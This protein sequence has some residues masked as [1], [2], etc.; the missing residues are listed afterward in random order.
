MT[1]LRILVGSFIGFPTTRYDA[2][3]SD[4]PV[5]E[6]LSSLLIEMDALVRR[7]YAEG[8]QQG[9]SDTRERMNRVAL[10]G[11]EQRM[12]AL[13]GPGISQPSEQTY[14]PPYNGRRT[15]PKVG[16]G[17]ASRMNYG[18][19]I[20]TIRRGVLASPGVGMSI[21]EMVAFCRE[22]GIDAT[23]NAVRDSVKRLRGAEE[24][25]RIDKSYF[26]GPRLQGY[27]PGDTS[28]QSKS[29]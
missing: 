24:V 11:M 27:V 21:N 7:A 12:P 9:V 13:L 1:P 22:K 16:L 19:V 26:P 17:D 8:Y 23:P 20:G 14:I 28:E 6:R 15:P 3:M 29:E 25:V 5:P 4:S 2:A 18:S 10:A